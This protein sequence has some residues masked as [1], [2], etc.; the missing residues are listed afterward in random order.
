MHLLHQTEL[1]RKRL[2]R[3]LLIDERQKGL[4]TG[5]DLQ[6]RNVDLIDDDTHVCDR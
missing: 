4:H 5:R 3:P 1:L 2:S 6:H